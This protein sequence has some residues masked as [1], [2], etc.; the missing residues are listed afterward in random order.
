MARNFPREMGGGLNKRE[1][2]RKRG[3]VRK[4]RTFAYEGRGR[5]RG[6][7]RGRGRGL[8]FNNSGA[9]VPNE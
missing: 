6:R 5:G 1:Y 3:G 4:K 7:W 9:H 2:V 8:N